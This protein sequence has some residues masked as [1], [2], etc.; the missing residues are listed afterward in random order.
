VLK[1]HIYYA[2]W[3]LKGDIQTD[4]VGKYVRDMTKP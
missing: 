1:G 4:V 3:L 2:F